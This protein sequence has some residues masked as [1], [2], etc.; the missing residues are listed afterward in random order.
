MISLI[1][2]STQFLG[3]DSAIGFTLLARIIQS[4]GSLLNIIFISH[5]LTNEQQGYYYTFGS[6]VAIQIFFELGLNSIIIQFVAHEA[7]HLDLVD[8]NLLIGS[9][10]QLSRI[11][12]LLRFSIKLFISISI[13]L[14]IILLISGNYF[15]N[16]FKHDNSI[17]NWQKPWLLLSLST[18]LILIMN[19]IMGFLQ[20]LGKV[21]EVAKVI[22]IQQI[23]VMILSLIVLYFK[24]GLWAIAVSSF[25][26][27]TVLF[28]YF[29]YGNRNKLLKFIWNS[30]DK[31]KIS[32]I[33]EIFPYQWK[34]A[35]SW[36]S[37]YFIFQ[38]FNPVLFAREGPAIAGKM[39]ITIAVLNGITGLSMSWITTKVPLFSNFIA[40]KKFNDLDSVFNKSTKEMLLITAVLL[41]FFNFFIYFFQKFNIQIGTRFLTTKYL[42]L[43][44]ITTLFNQL[45]FSWATYLRC[46]KKE[47]FLINS[48]FIGV[49]CLFST[50]FFGKIYGLNGIVIG[51]TFITIFISVP[52]GYYIF[53]NKKKTWH[54]SLIN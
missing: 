7:V 6:L 27:F 24:G 52:W 50:V 10:V 42:L 16:N 21:K 22:L 47:P 20:G 26:S 28:I 31:W 2:K 1:K 23:T 43:L 3:I 35:L 17:I 11:S 18:S 36:I 8:D 44:S 46:H 53:K 45:T 9:K 39:G 15:F 30:I 14:F 49:L 33:S 40:K 25:G 48:I 12:S 34:I 5:F 32:Y 54:I 19:P 13:L 51:Y 41:F 38:L 29:L 37:G 4:V